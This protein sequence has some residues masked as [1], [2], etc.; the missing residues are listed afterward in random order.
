M[1]Y[2][3]Y[4][5]L[6]FA[7]AVYIFLVFYT[8]M[9]IDSYT[10]TGLNFTKSINV[11][12]DPGHGGD[13]GG[14]VANGIIEKSI[15]LTVSKNLAKLLK[16][17][18]FN[19]IMT[20]DSDRMINTEGKTLRE[21]KISDM[22]NRLKIYN[23]DCDNVV[24]SIHQNKFTE[25]KYY[26]TQVF[27]SNNNTDSQKL[28]E[29]IRN[30]IQTLIQPDNKREIKQSDSSIYLLKNSESPSVIVECGFI[31]NNRE[32]RLLK[33]HNYQKKIAFA[34]YTGFMDYYLSGSYNK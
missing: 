6:F 17:G 20:R 11:I 26:G 14:A 1:R 19:V 21:R 4:I 8:L 2:K 32:A 29:S 3:K 5:I 25:E 9:N 18:G 16:S 27:Y 15:N 23:S 12:I 13:D 30:N 34:I 33:T 7:F 24:I 10:N 31:S 22:K 28:A